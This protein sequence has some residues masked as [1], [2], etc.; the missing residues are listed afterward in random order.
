LDLGYD[1]RV[2]N[3]SPIANRQ[4]RINNLDV[5]CLGE[6]LIDFVPSPALST[7]GQARYLRIA[8]GGAPANVA[9]ALRRLGLASGFIGKAG[10]DPFGR[11]LRQVLARQHLD[12]SLFE[13]TTAAQTRLAFVTND[14]NE[15][16]R[17]IFY[18]DPG[19]DVLL[20]SSEIKV[21]YLRRARVLHFGSISLIRE[22]ARS[23]TLAAIRLA[24]QN[25]LL[26]SFD[27]NLRPALWPNLKQARREILNALGYCDILKVNESEWEFLF[28]GRRFEEAFSLLQKRGIKLAA[29]TLG[30]KGAV[31]ATCK[32][33]AKVGSPS[34]RVV[35]TTGTGDG[36]VAALLYGVLK[37]GEQE[38]EFGDS[39]L[40]EMGQFATCV[41]ALTATKPGA[42]LSFP[43]LGQVKAFLKRTKS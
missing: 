31:L 15:H 43:S 41:G 5:V 38:L 19:A 3:K 36:F 27:P 35:D 8:P 32:S 37:S 6:I 2:R 23:A 10:D 24:C 17:F 13:L 4:T 25:G 18:G 14:S 9:V 21:N 40:K 11:Y 22:P 39:E 29:V 30:P 33:L 42:I 12:L 28:P 1:F 16:Q 7:L 34:V 26:V 20:Q